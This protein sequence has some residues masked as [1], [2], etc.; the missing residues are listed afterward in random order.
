MTTTTNT[1]RAE[2]SNTC[3]IHADHIS[4]TSD[5]NVFTSDEFMPKIN[6]RAIIQFSF[7]F[8]HHR[9]QIHYFEMMIKDSQTQ[10]PEIGIGVAAPKYQYGMTGWS[11]HSI[12]Y[13]ADDGHVYD[14]HNN[15][16]ISLNYYRYKCELFGVNDTVGL[17]YDRQNGGVTFTRNGQIVHP[18]ITPDTTWG[19]RFGHLVGKMEYPLSDEY[20]ERLNGFTKDAHFVPTVTTIPGITFSVNFGHDQINKP[21]A[22]SGYMMFG[23]IG[24]MIHNLQCNN[25]VDV[26]IVRGECDD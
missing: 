25:F 26:E 10:N 4:T 3:I 13:H 7:H 18:E 8:V 20:M 16:D 11:K 14:S 21:F 1:H 19:S 22:W 5:P 17:I 23:S 6:K 15:V 24:A 2:E 9:N 12:G